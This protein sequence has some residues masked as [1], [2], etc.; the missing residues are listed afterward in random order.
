M[1]VMYYIHMTSSMMSPGKKVGQIL[2]LPSVFIIQP[3][4]KY[5]HN[6]YTSFS[7]RF[8][9]KDHQS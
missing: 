4:D 2:K 7:F 1:Q 9:F 5:C 6:L 3:E 8:S